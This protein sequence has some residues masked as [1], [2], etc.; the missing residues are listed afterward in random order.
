[1]LYVLISI[2]YLSLLVISCSIIFLERKRPEKTIAWLSIFIF[3]PPLGIFLYIFIGRNWKRRRLSDERTLRELRGLVKPILRKDKYKKFAS[4][5]NLITNNSECPVFYNNNI[6]IYKDGNEKF[7]EFKEDLRNAKQNIHLEYYIVNSDEIGNEIKDIL[8]DK[9]KE[10]VKVRFIVDKMGSAHTKKRYIDEMKSNGVDIEIYSYFLAPF[11]RFINTQINY[12]NHRKIAVIDGKIG[13]IGGINIGDEYLGKGKLGYWRDTTLRIEGEAALG[14][15]GF[16]L[17]DYFDIKRVNKSSMTL[18]KDIKSLFPNTHERYEESL[19]QLVKSGPNSEYPNIMHAIIKMITMA[20]KKIYIT[21]P[22]FVP[23]E[24]I[25]EALKIAIISGVDV[26]I[27]FP[28]KPD[29]WIVY[30]ASRTYLY[31]LLKCGAK[32]YFYKEDSFIHSKVM[33]IDGAFGTVGSANM[34]IRSFE[35]NHEANAIIYDEII[36]GELDKQFFEDI[37]KSR[38]VSIN[39]LELCSRKVR[40]YEGLA[41]IFSALL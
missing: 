31:E 14:L 11:L 35:L 36:I 15:Q 25:M 40:I 13:Y 33:T 29:H 1:M 28:G 12:R 41:R 21:T 38:V 19:V 24:S 17:D 18:P 5:V 30:Y 26:R 39:E 3:L 37:K 8:I 27:L 22:Y 32:V 9:A 10:G 16:F 34:D 6:R 20:T 4:L 23:S 2:I 7:L